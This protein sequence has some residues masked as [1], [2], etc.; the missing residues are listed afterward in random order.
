MSNKGEMTVGSTARQE[1]GLTPERLVKRVK[2]YIGDSIF[3]LRS[4]L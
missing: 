4:I 1:R 2:N 3:L